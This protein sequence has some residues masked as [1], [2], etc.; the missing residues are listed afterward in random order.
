MRPTI[1]LIEA[2]R[3]IVGC[4]KLL[5]TRRREARAGTRGYSAL[6]KVD[7]FIYGGAPAA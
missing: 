4:E 5:V 2:A 6:K 1:P 3:S 7:A